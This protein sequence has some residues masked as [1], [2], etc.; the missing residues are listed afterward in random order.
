MLVPYRR[1]C[2]SQRDCYLRQVREECLLVQPTSR[3]GQL[4][5][6]QP[7]RSSTTFPGDEPGSAAFVSGADASI[8]CVSGTPK[9]P[10][11]LYN[12][13]YTPPAND[14]VVAFSSS[15]GSSTRY[16]DCSLSK[17]GFY[18]LRPGP[19]LVLSR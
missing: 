13:H 16:A 8:F 14:T 10:K 4:A 6:E 18:R 5:T 3:F 12:I 9:C 2:R 15:L 7:H 1:G 17:P 19:T 11:A